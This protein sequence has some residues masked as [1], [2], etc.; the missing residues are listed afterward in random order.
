MKCISS[1][2]IQNM[3]FYLT[4][5]NHWPAFNVCNS[6]HVK[7]VCVLFVRSWNLSFTSVVLNRKFSPWSCIRKG[8]LSLL[9]LRKSIKKLQKQESVPSKEKLYLSCTSVSN[10][11]TS[12]CK[13]LL[14]DISV[15]SG[16]SWTCY[17]NTLLMLKHYRSFSG[18]MIL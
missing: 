2:N 8:F 1:Q 3:N 13:L 5:E 17:T 4:F 6:C 18:Y 7:L 12:H 11:S 9:K 14:K 16:A 10:A 15:F